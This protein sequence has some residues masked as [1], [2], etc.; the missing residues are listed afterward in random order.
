MSTGEEDPSCSC[1]DCVFVYSA[2]RAGSPAIARGATTA[3]ATAAGQTSMSNGG[4]AGA[5][6]EGMYDVSA[7]TSV[8]I[9]IGQGGK[10]GT[11]SV[12]HACN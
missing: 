8:M 3:A 10:G 11:Q 5:Y 12:G 6:A 7:L 1:S 9:T 4:G 2:V